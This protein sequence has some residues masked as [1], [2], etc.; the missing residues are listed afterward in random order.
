MKVQYDQYD[1][2]LEE[3][4]WLPVATTAYQMTIPT[5]A[6][7]IPGSFVL[8]APGCLLISSLERCSMKSLWQTQEAI[9]PSGSQPLK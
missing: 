2:S 7:L 8:P 6:R 4:G 3:G 9:H 5:L 1:K